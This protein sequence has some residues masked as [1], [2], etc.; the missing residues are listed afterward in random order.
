MTSLQP[1]KD[2]SCILGPG[3]HPFLKHDSI[4]NYKDAR[5]VS[6]DVLRR[7]HSR[8]EISLRGSV[9]LD[10]LERIRAGFANSRFAVKEHK[11]ILDTQGL[12]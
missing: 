8:N 9:E 1:G 2:E 11:E 5:V 10:V 7:L 4:M 3:D 6:I 12:L